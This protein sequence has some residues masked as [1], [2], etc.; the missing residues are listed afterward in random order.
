MV[1]G[2][3]FAGEE[4]VVRMMLMLA[5]VAVAAVA[6]QAVVD[7][8]E[9][10]PDAAYQ[11]GA[12]A[13]FAGRTDKA[14]EYL[15]TAIEYAPHDPR[16]YYLR[17]L[18]YLA[19]GDTQKAGVD[20]AEGARLEAQRGTSSPLVDRSLAAVQGPAR[21]TLE[22]IR[23]AARESAEV[24]ERQILAR[25]RQ[26]ARQQRE[27]RVLRTDFQLPMEALASRLTVEQA[28][29]VASKD[30]TGDSV[31]AME[32]DAAMAQRSPAAAVD[33]DNPFADDAEDGSEVST[34]A[35]QTE[36]AGASGNDAQVPE[37][38]RGSMKASSL[39]GIFGKAGRRALGGVG[40]AAEELAG[41][42]MGAAGGPNPFDESGVEQGGFDQGGFDQGGFEQESFDGG[43]F[44][45]GGFEQGAF[46]EGGF[47]EQG[48]QQD[49]AEPPAD[50][51]ESPFM[52][53]EQ[54]NPFDFGE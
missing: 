20:L 31:A 52:D 25:A 3:L 50:G 11:R 8:Q 29:R 35:V 36:M 34:A 15:T 24:E 9:I 13:Y 7:A 28:L 43:Q 26:E 44:G 49:T 4:A 17:G 19:A 38:A 51:E 40:A 10:T 23:R 33:D 6:P 54:E 47:D 37:A 14:Q 46:D 2:Q 1:V 21:V 16:A 12:G 42:A 27:Q 53:D 41:E 48:M 39:F 45:E 32:G 30:R 5:C 22:R 18:N